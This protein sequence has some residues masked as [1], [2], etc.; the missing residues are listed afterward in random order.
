MTGKMY[1]GKTT[2]D[3][4]RRI[5]EHI[6]DASKGSTTPFHVALREYGPEAFTF[7]IV[8]CEDSILSDA[9]GTLIKQNGNGYNNLCPSVSSYFVGS[10]LDGEKIKEFYARTKKM[11]ADEIT[12]SELNELIV[13]AGTVKIMNDKML[14]EPPFDNEPPGVYK[15]Q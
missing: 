1:V 5:A 8:E 15:L 14:G 2:R 9:E 3:F 12:T 11:F 10:K 13:V 6:R 7:E 4:N